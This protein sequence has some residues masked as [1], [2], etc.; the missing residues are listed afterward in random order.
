M[1]QGGSSEFLADGRLKRRND[2][3]LIVSMMTEKI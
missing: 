2:G 3:S 1:T